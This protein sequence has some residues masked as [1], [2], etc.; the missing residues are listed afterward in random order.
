M[1]VFEEPLADGTAGTPGS[2]NGTSDIQLGINPP[3]PAER[4][5]T[6]CLQVERLCHE[7]NRRP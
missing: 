4:E 5:I 3:V 7:P 2:L 6:T 1:G